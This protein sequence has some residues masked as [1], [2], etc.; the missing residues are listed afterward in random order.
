MNDRQRFLAIMDFKSVDRVPNYE[1]GVWGQTIDRW[2]SEGMPHDSAYWNWSEG[3]PFSRIERRGFA[4]I[5]MEMLPPFEYEVLEESERY[6]VARHANGIV[7]RALKEGT[8]R[9]TR[10]S[11]DTYID[12]PVKD[13]ASFRELK[14]RYDPN[15][16]VRY[17][18]WWDMMAAFWKTR[19]HPLCLLGNGTAGLYSQL[20]SWVGTENISYLFFDDPALVH[21]MVEFNVDFILRVTERARTELSFDYFNFFEDFAGKGGPLVSPQ[22]FREFLLPGYRRIIG[23]FRKSG[24]RHFWLDSDGDPRPLIP[25]MIEAGISCLWPL[26]VASDMDALALRKQYGTSLVLAGGIDKRELTRTRKEIDRELERRIPPLLEQGG[27]L[28]H[29]DHTFPP[30]ISY[31]NFRYH[32]ERKMRLLGY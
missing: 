3:E 1:L 12:F 21:E 15:S 20:R 13:R 30:D 27:Y 2:Y 9:G 4:R 18:L 16:A 25:L 17:P 26:E 32:L 5:S 19:D 24:I 8:V 31:D 14:K 23:E 28:P 6:I 22:L 7:T 10:A 29:L 11:M